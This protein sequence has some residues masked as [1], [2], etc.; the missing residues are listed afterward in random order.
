MWP[1]IGITI[2][3][4]ILTR[5]HNSTWNFDPEFQFHVELWPRVIIAR[6]NVTPGHNS[7]LNC[8]PGRDCT[9]KF[10]PGSIFHVELWPQVLIQRWLMTPIH[11][12][13]L[14][15]NPD[16][17][18]NVKLWPGIGIKIQRGIL[19]RLHIFYPWNCDSRR[20]QNINS[21]IKIQQIRRVTIQ[22]EIHWILTPGRYSMR[23]SKFYLTP[24]SIMSREIS[25]KLI[26]CYRIK[27][28]DKLYNPRSSG[29][30]EGPST[31]NYIWQSG[32]FFPRR[33]PPCTSPGTRVE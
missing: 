19:T 24:A 22:R 10:Y 16:S 4:G 26:S 23:G 27:P 28:I 8:D 31:T 13:T 3:C 14:N 30:V 17:W 18:F 2:E 7:T 9:L 21:V 25:M 1:G 15:C 20:C 29:K 33:N 12:S 5:G 32:T 11:D 6:P